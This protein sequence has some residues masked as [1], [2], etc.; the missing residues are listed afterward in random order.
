MKLTAASTVGEI[1]R[2]GVSGVLYRDVGIE[3]DHAFRRWLIGSVKA[4]YGNDTISGAERQH[5]WHVRDGVRLPR[6][7]GQ[8]PPIAMTTAILG[9]GLTYKI[10]RK[11]SSRAKRGTNGCDSNVTGERLHRQHIPARP[12]L[13]VLIIRCYFLPSR[14]LQL[15]AQCAGPRSGRSSA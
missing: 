12:A 2:A 8:R 14:R 13:A 7:A 10:N 15:G 1:R 9:A 6:L 5:R 4:G 3:V 11:C